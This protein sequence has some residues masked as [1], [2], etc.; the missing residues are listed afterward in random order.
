MLLILFFVLLT[1]SADPCENWN[2]LFT[3]ENA[4]SCLR[5]VEFSLYESAFNEE[6]DAFLDTYINL[7]TFNQH[8]K[9]GTGEP[10]NMKIDFREEITSLKSKQYTSC[11]TLNTTST[12][13]I[14]EI[15]MLTLVGV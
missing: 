8:M 15:V 2:S 4:L 11:L 13:S 7:Y 10:L 14:T 3:R 5:N 12:K 9:A 1:F 6:I